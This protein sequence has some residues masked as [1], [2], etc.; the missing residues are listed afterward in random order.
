MPHMKTASEEV[1]P[2]FRGTNRRTAPFDAY[3]HS[4]NWGGSVQRAPTG[5]FQLL[6]HGFNQV[7]WAN[8]N[9]KNYLAKISSLSVVPLTKFLELFDV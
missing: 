8:A 6:S 2:L 7:F 9:K 5:V 3:L 1:E 4:E